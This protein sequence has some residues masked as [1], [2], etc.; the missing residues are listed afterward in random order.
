MKKILTSL[1]L[2]TIIGGA[3]VS[4]TRSF[5]SDTETSE[6]NVFET[7]AIDL[8]IGNESVY[9][10]N[11]SVATSWELKDLTGVEKFFNFTDLKPG[12]W[13]NDTI[14]IK[15][16]TNPAWACANVKFTEN[17]DST[18]TE[19]EDMM[20]SL[21]DNADGTPDGDLAENLQFRFW[22]ELHNNNKQDPDEVPFLAGT[23]S[24]ILDGAT[25]ALADTTQNIFT[26]STGDDLDAGQVYKIGKAFCYGEFSV[27]NDIN[28]PGYGCDGTPVSNLSQTDRLVGDLTFYAEQNRNNNQFVCNDELFE[29]AP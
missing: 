24:D 20:D 6:E 1:L 13:G 23:A 29:V 11:P 19:P 28:G 15:V 3:L 18:F 12:D 26:N 2:I 17:S 27:N 5:F 21:L 4:Q 22:V 9:L 8:Q 10:G 25:Y 16:D 7:G 14:S